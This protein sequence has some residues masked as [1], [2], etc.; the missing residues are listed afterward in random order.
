MISFAAQMGYDKLNQFLQGTNQR[1]MKHASA[2]PDPISMGKMIN[3][4]ITSASIQIRLNIPQGDGPVPVVAYF[5]GGGFTLMSIDT[6]DDM[7]RHLCSKSGCIVIS[8]EYRLASENPYPKGLEDCVPATEWLIEHAMDFNGLCN[9]PAVAPVDI[10][11]YIP[12]KNEL[13]QGLGRG[14]SLQLTR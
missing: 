3:M 12:L 7:C 2:N 6:H 1:K 4:E 9:Q 11:H 14:H 13:R 10:W 8:V 5:H